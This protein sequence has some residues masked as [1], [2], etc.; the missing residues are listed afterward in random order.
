MVNIWSCTVCICFIQLREYK[1]TSAFFFFLT[2]KTFS[3]TLTDVLHVSFLSS[4]L[5]MSY[6]TD[7]FLALQSVNSRCLVIRHIFLPFIFK[8][9]MQ[10]I[11]QIS[12]CFLNL[13][14]KLNIFNLCKFIFQNKEPVVIRFCQIACTKQL[15]PDLP[16]SIYLFGLSRILQL[17]GLQAAISIYIWM[18][19]TQ[20]GVRIL[21]INYFFTILPVFPSRYTKMNHEK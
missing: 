8:T 7:W 10:M 20:A 21:I 13:S 2:E 14:S 4:N 17:P 19:V 3:I 6:L 11:F 12:T 5:I 18:K 9:M 15:L 16:V 1:V